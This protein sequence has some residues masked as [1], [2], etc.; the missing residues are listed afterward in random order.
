MKKAFASLG[1]QKMFGK[2]DRT[3]TKFPASPQRPGQTSQHA[4]K[5]APR[6]SGTK[7]RSA[8]VDEAGDMGGSPGASQPRRPAA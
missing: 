6:R 2:G 5:A 8:A 7:V 4:G 1:K 3:V